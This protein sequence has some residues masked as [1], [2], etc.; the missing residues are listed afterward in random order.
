MAYFQGA[1]GVQTGLDRAGRRSCWSRDV[2]NRCEHSADLYG[3]GF[4][5]FDEVER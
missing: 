2:G 4:A 1:F 5:K 3:V